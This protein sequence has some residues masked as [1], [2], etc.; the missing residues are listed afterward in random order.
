MSV[1]YSAWL[2]GI[3]SLSVLFHSWLQSGLVQDTPT[4]RVE[5]HAR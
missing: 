1:I 3:A 4:L 5:G 2:S